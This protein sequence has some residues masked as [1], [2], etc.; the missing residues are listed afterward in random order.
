M[1]NHKKLTRDAPVNLGASASITLGNHDYLVAPQRIGWLRSRFGVALQGLDTSE[2]S[3]SN[4]MD[5]LL[6]RAHGV[7]QVFIPDLMPIYEFNGF[8]TRE[9]MVEDNYD[10]E[11]D[12]SPS[13]TQVKEA[14][15]RCAELNEMDLLKHLGKLIGPDLIQTWAQTLMIDSMKASLE[16][17]SPTSGDGTSITPGVANPT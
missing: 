16:S 8:A 10:P 13:A 9:A 15:L 3:Q 12:K 17:S 1:T 7:L 14:L 11:Y 2:L 5:F 6:Q 4:V